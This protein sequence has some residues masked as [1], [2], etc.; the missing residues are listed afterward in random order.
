MVDADNALITGSIPVSLT[1]KE[2]HDTFNDCISLNLAVMREEDK[3]WKNRIF[4]I[5]P[6]RDAWRNHH[7]LRV[8]EKT[9]GPVA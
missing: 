3:V 1:S 2:F 9:G 6:C 8:A 4:T 5:S 7:P